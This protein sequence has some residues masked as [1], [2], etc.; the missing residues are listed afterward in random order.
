MIQIKNAIRKECLM[1]VGMALFAGMCPTAIAA[2]LCVNPGGTGGC[3]SK[4]ASAVS[5]A[6]TNDIIK[7]APGTYKED[8]V[9]GKLVSLIGANRETTIIDAAGLP[10]GIYIDGIDNPKLGGV[11][12]SGFTI[13]NA[14]F[15]GILITNAV[16]VTIWNNEVTNND[17]SLDYAA[18]QCPGL[19]PFET[20]EHDDCGEGIHLM[21]VY[22][23][24]VSRNVVGG[25]AGGIELSDDTG[26]TDDNLITGNVVKDNV[27]DCGIT[28]ASHLPASLTGSKFPLG[29]FHNT[30]AGN[31]STGNGTKGQGA[32]AGIFDSVPGARNF[33]NVVILNKL[34]GNGSTGVALHSHTPGQD[35]N[36]NMIAGNYISGNGPDSGDAATPGPTGINVF[37]VSPVYGTVI[38]ENVIDN[39]AV[40]IAVNTAAEVEIHLNN[41]LDDTIGVDNLG[42]GLVDAK[43]NWWACTGGPGASGCAT[44]SG[45]VLFAPWLTAALPKP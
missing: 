34:I 40:Q 19:P 18:A 1:A 20:N 7:V 33:N 38:S 25:N 11:I 13:E 4:I 42:S 5:A 12:V 16:S 21:G 45:S 44:V 28:L 9:I 29:V 15:E 10:N 43:Q 23:S 6:S 31:E 35:L 32:G 39:E 26:E 14:N 30:V 27:Y 24:T 17:K 8:V 22:G 37:G 36:N 41:F 3:Y 2:T